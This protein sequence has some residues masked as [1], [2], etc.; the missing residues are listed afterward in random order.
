[1]PLI[2]RFTLLLFVCFGVIFIGLILFYP[3]VFHAIFNLQ[4][5]FHHAISD[6]LQHLNQSSSHTPLFLILLCFGYGVFH[7][8]GPGHG[9]FILTSYLT[10]NATY[11]K[12]SMGLAMLSSL[13]QGLVAIILT[14]VVIAIF[15]LPTYFY[16]LS[17]QW[18]ERFSFILM[19]GLGVWW[20]WRAYRQYRHQAVSHQHQIKIK[21]CYPTKAPQLVVQPLQSNLFSLS[22]SCDCGHQHLPSTHQLAQAKDWQSQLMIILSIGA[23]PCSGAILVLFL[24]YLLKLYPYGILAVIAMSIGTGLTLSGFALLVLFARQ[25]AVQLSAWYLQPRY[26]QQLAYWVKAILSVLLIYMGV[27]LLYGSTLPVSG[28]RALFG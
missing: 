14:T 23:R 2:R 24:S 19:I 22:G 3:S 6:T 11:V 18:L 9:K 12:Q 28:G 20:L 17:Q 21:K 8:V 13:V 4:R 26:N 27:A 25:K 10:T 5:W 1:M 15:N 7:A 16:K